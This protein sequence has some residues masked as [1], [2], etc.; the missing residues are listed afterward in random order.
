M[1]EP[2]TLS[3]KHVVSSQGLEVH[4]TVNNDLAEPIYVL[5]KLYERARQDPDNANAELSKAKLDPEGVYRYV[6]GSSLRL[7]LGVAP[8]PRGVNVRVRNVPWATKVEPKHAAHGTLKLAL[9]I[10][11]YSAYFNAQDGYVPAKVQSFELFVEYHRGR[12]VETSP[13]SGASDALEITGG[14]PLHD[15]QLLRSGPQAVQLDALTNANKPF[16]RYAP[17][18]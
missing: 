12:A 13:V 18:D 9:P 5:D 7:L 14:A 6:V 8:L 17:E 1:Q 3:V 11:E 10:K 15:L 4:Y 2:V 16:A